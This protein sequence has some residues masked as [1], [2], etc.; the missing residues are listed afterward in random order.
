MVDALIVAEPKNPYFYEL[1]GQMLF[2]NGR[3]ADAEA[4]YRQAVRYRP[5]SALLRLG[6]ARTLLEQSDPT[7]P[8]T[9]KSDEAVAMLREATRL[10]PQDPGMWRFL[11]IA[12]GTQGKE[13][14]ASMAL[15]EY[16]IQ[17]GN[18]SDAQLYIHRAQETIKPSDPEW[19]RLQDQLRTVEAMRDP[20]RRQ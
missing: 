7:K 19:I 16:A 20:E 5:N 6:L 9:A 4:P 15:A 12:Y 18:K 1:K 17:V 11:G 3:A 10:E 13:G 14:P 8:I 2:E